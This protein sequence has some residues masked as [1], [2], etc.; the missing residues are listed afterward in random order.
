MLLPAAD[1]THILKQT[2]PLWDDLRGRR[3]FVTGGTGFFG[4]WLV[5]SFLHINRELSLGSTISILTRDPASFRKAA[6]SIALHPAVELIAGNVRHLDPQ[7]GQYSH[8]IHAATDASAALNNTNPVLMYDTIIEGTRR[9]LDLAVN[10]GAERLLFTSSGAVYGK[11]PPG[12]SHLQ[13]EYAGSP[14][15]LDPTAAYANAK[16]AAEHLCVLYARQYQV[17]PLIARCFAFVGPH[18]PLD[19]HFAIGNFIRDALSGGPIIIKGDGTPRRSYL[20]AADLAICLW[21]ILLRGEPCRPYNVG[22]EDSVSIADVAHTVASCV[23]PVVPVE[24]LGRPLNPAVL[25]QYVPSTKRAATELGLRQNFSLAEAIERT[26][27][28]LHSTTPINNEPK[29]SLPNL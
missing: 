14:E 12:I 3:L 17:K 23:S 10:C 16:R 6:P 21:T 26:L 27:L 18:L 29:S 13:E 7:S 24:I 22:S 15:V 8:I 28:S 9:V 25:E 19:I 2:G 20:Y 11:Q 1:L 5:G 4:K